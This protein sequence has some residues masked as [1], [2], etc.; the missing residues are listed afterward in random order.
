MEQNIVELVAHMLDRDENALARLIS[1]V[2]DDS[3]MV[4]K[5]RE[6]LS[7]Y[8]GRTHVIGVT[9]APG[10]G[11]SVLV[12]QLVAVIRNKGLTVGVIAVDPSSPI[13]GGAI[14][15]DRVRMQRHYLDN[16][17]FIRSMATRGNCGGLSRAVGP[18]VDLLD[19]FGKD[20]VLVETVGVGQT[21]V[22]IKE[23]ADT[24][25]LVLTPGC[26][27]ALQFMKAGI[28]E[29]ADI[30]VVNKADLEGCDRLVAELRSVLMLSQNKPEKVIITT[31]ALY[32]VGMNQLYEELSRQW[33]LKERR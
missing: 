32:G 24:L 26:G 10:V 31:Q 21:E 2:E 27:D 1:I 16:G 4:S 19:A 6:L 5:I 33:S 8:L 11:K 18:A 15:G 17:V 14:L 29:V 20:I 25:I 28:M 3:A 9:G 12:D 30:V 13:C 22:G 7:P 23:I